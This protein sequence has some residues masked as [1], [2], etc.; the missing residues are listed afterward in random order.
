MN[1]LL[2]L[3]QAERKSIFTRYGEIFSHPLFL[4][5]LVIACAFVY[6]LYRYYVINDSQYTE[7]ESYM[8]S[9]LAYYG[10]G[11][12]SAELREEAGPFAKIK[13]ERDIMDNVK[14]TH[15]Y[16][17]VHASDQSKE[18]KSFWVK[19]DYVGGKINTVHWLPDIEE[20]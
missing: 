6:V 11:F 13:E 19:L 7:E 15:A 5:M 17:V 9:Q 14:R 8:R 10:L 2:F 16:Y 1:I 20:V 12:T 3:L 4:V 18:R